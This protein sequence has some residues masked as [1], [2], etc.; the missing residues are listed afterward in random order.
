MAPAIKDLQLD[1]GRREMRLELH[2]LRRVV[3]E[4]PRRRRVGL[5]IRGFVGDV[6]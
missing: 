5:W 1:L 3:L 6:L 4:N 2:L